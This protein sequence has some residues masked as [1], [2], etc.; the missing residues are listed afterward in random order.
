MMALLDPDLLILLLQELSISVQELLSDLKIAQAVTT[1]EPAL[2]PSPTSTVNNVTHCQRLNCQREIFEIYL[3]CSLCGCL[4]LNCASGGG[5]PNSGGC[6][7][8]HKQPERMHNSSRFQNNY[9]SRNESQFRFHEKCK[10]AKM[11]GLEQAQ[12]PLKVKCQIDD[13][14][15]NN[16]AESILRQELLQTM[17]SNDFAECPLT[18][19]SLISME[20][21][22][23]KNKD[24]EDSG[25]LKSSIANSRDC[26]VSYNRNISCEDKE[27][28]LNVYH[29]HA[30]GSKILLKSPLH[31]I[32][33]TAK[34][35][36]DLIINLYPDLQNEVI[37][38]LDK[39]S[40]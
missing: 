6:I 10:S 33:K 34:D 40:S 17:S 3:S 39:Y 36:S 22:N 18:I 4:C 11:H 35:M 37:Q 8:Y 31:E 12:D 26:D 1:L 15:L 7:E 23:V 14:S 9:S 13:V 21:A 32:E 28:S 19:D 30:K 29:I 25:A 20:S 27:H 5:D 24:V 2:Q 16:E 38:I